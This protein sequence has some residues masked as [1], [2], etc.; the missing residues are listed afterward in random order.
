MRN[1]IVARALRGRLINKI[2]KSVLLVYGIDNI[3]TDLDRRVDIDPKRALVWALYYYT[4]LPLKIIGQRVGCGYCNTMYLVKTMN[5]LISTDY[6]VAN[7]TI[8]LEKL[9]K[10]KK[11]KKRN[12]PHKHAS[13]GNSLDFATSYKKES[14]RPV[15]ANKKVTSIL[16]A[17]ND[18]KIIKSILKAKRSQIDKET[19]IDNVVVLAKEIQSL[20]FQLSAL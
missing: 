16:L 1:D 5:G 3:T 9:L 4:S 7:T 17:T 11:L 18:T 13:V 14:K 12:R 6:R 10:Q 8:E 15:V 19:N 2:T 20:E